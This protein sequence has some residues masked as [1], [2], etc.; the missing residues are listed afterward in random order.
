MVERRDLFTDWFHELSRCKQ[1]IST[2]NG[3]LF[4][5]HDRVSTSELNDVLVTYV[6]SETTHS[7]ASIVFQRSRDPL[8]ANGDESKRLWVNVSKRV[9]FSLQI[10]KNGKLSL[11]V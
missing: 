9:Q 3:S 5:K 6:S 10:E 4:K 1:V 7:F 11:G 8:G 2:E